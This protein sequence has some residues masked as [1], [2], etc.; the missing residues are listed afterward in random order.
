MSTYQKDSLQW[1][2]LQIQQRLGQWWEQQLNKLN[3][4]FPS[5]DF[6]QWG[7]WSISWDIIKFIIITILLLLLIWS[8]S[9]IWPSILAYLNRA[10]DSVSEEKSPPPV[11]VSQWLER[12]RAFKSGGN[13]FGACRCLYFAALEKL[14]LEGI[15][16]QQSSLTDREYTGLTLHLPNVAAYHTLFTIHQELCFGDREASLSL[17]EECEKAYEKI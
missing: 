2:W 16:P 10:G 3:I 6:F 5:K 1:Q 15:V 11:S 8:I 9:R 14:H 17:L 12:Y 4:S 7:G 13:Y